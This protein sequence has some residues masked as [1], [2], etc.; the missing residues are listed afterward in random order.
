MGDYNDLLEN[1][2]RM[3]KLKSIVT[4]YERHLAITRMTPRGSELHYYG[5]AR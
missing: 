1:T 2:S 3:F 5:R 4:I